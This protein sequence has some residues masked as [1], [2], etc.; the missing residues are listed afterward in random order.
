MSNKNVPNL[1]ENQ[2]RKKEEEIKALKAQLEILKQTLIEIASKN[3][4]VQN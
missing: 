1:L 3:S 4:H 2:L